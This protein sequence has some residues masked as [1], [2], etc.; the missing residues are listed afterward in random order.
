MRPASAVAGAAR[1]FSARVTLRRGDLRVDA[2]NVM[3]LLT[4]AAEQGS[5]LTVEAEGPDAAAALETLSGLLAAP[6]PPG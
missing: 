4:L 6:E 1:K 3:D 5:E 2:R